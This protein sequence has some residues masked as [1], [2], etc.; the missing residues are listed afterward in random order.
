MLPLLEGFP[1]AVLTVHLAPPGVH[2]ATT[3]EGL[4][5][6]LPGPLLRHATPPL[7]ARPSPPPR[8]LII[9]ACPDPQRIPG[10]TGAS[11]LDPPLLERKSINRYADRLI[12]RFD[13]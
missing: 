12:D 3:L 1:A 7:S 8:S 6:T 11:I 2:H 9:D 13:Q 5:T 10:N 4:L